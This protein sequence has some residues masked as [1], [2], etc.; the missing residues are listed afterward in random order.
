MNTMGE[1]DVMIKQKEFQCLRPVIIA[2]DPAH[3]CL[4]GIN[5]LVILAKMRDVID[6][7]MKARL[8]DKEKNSRYKSDSIATRLNNVCLPRILSNFDFGILNN[9]ETKPSIVVQQKSTTPS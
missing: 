6:V 3:D 8:S 9:V 1:C 5:V 2:V 7:L 4:I